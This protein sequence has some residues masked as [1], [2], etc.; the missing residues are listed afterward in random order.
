[1]ARLI[2]IITYLTQKVKRKINKKNNKKISQNPLTNPHRCAI[3]LS[4]GEGGNRAHLNWTARYNQH[5]SKAL[6]QLRVSQHKGE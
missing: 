3:I 1:M 5:T 2:T 6:F 4:E